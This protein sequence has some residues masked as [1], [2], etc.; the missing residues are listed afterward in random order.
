MKK[1]NNRIRVGREPWLCYRHSLNLRYL[2]KYASRLLKRA[3]EISELSLLEGDARNS[4]FYDEIMTRKE[5]GSINLSR[6]HN[7][8]D[9]LLLVG[10]V[11]DYAQ[12]NPSISPHHAD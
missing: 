9:I 5:H 6:F 8:L 1:C 7:A 11:H 4:V 3:V 10:L 2:Q 12:D